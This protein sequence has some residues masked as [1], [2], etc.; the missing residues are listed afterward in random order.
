MF[1][2]NYQ[3]IIIISGFFIF[4]ILYLFSRLSLNHTRLVYIIFILYAILL[5]IDVSIYFCQHIY[6]L[7]EGDSTNYI[8]YMSENNPVTPGSSS[9][10]SSAR[11]VIQ[12]TPTSDPVRWWPSGVPQA[13][14]VI[15]SG[16][17]TFR[18]LG[19]LNPRARFI[20]SLSAMGASTSLVMYNS[21]LIVGFNRFMFG[22]TEYN[23]TGRWPNIDNVQNNYTEERIE[24]TLQKAIDAFSKKGGSGSGSGSGPSVVV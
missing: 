2:N 15:G 24:S 5:I 10:G 23:R 17:I 20:A 22:L 12:V 21:T 18:T 13:W 9:S 14:A 1:F 16:L 4:I 19:G 3:P 7:S 8:L 11:T 6:I